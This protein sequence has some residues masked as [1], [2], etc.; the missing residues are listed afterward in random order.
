MK[1]SGCRFPAPRTRNALDYTWRLF[2]Q[3]KV[4]ISAELAGIVERMNCS[5]Q[6]WQ[7][8]MEK[9]RDGRLLGRFYATTRAKL[10]EIADRL[11]MQRLVNLA[12]CPV[13]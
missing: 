6:S 7:K 8:R 9:L 4:S 3:G 2:R 11:G 1:A 12:A 13:R 10:R 5:A